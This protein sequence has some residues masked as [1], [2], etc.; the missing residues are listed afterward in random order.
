MNTR[1]K[2]KRLET[3]AKTGTL[4]DVQAEFNVLDVKEQEWFRHSALEHAVQNPTSHALGITWFLME[5][6]V[7]ELNSIMFWHALENPSPCALEMVEFLMERGAK[8]GYYDLEYAAK[9][10]GPRAL[11]IVKLLMERGLKPDWRTLR[12]AAQNTGPCALEIVRYLMERGAKPDS[13]A[14]WWTAAHNTGPC[15]FD[16]VKL[17]MERGA[18]PHEKNVNGYTAFIQALCYGNNA[19]ADYFLSRDDFLLSD[20][21]PRQRDLQA[22]IYKEHRAKAIARVSELVDAKGISFAKM[23]AADIGKILK[24]E[25]PKPTTEDVETLGIIAKKI[26]TKDWVADAQ[27]S[28]DAF[29]GCD[30]ER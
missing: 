25:K 29:L 22:D 19:I 28:S 1:E 10:P 12:S 23:V 27:V 18:N 6:G 8:L 11:E 5:K 17:L 2:L 21:M 7:V 13:E 20:L 30:I 14:L 26:A 15:A 9:N 3:A 24:S 4:E 16:V